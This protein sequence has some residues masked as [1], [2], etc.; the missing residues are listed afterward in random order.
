MI[1]ILS[2]NSDHSTF[3]VIDWLDLWGKKWIKFDSNNSVRFLNLSIN[4]DSAS[5]DFEVEGHRISTVDIE[6]YWYRRDDFRF[7]LSVEVSKIGLPELENQLINHVNS[8][9]D[10]LRS[11]LHEVLAQKK[12]INDLRTSDLNK[13]DMLIKAQK[14][15]L[16]IP[17]TII[18]SNREDFEKFKS[19]YPQL[20]SKAIQ[21][22][23]RFQFEQEEELL[24]FL[25]YTEDYESEPPESFFPTLFQEKLDKEI[26]LRV[27]FL[28]GVCYS[29]AIFS[30]L[31]QRTQTDFR[32]YNLNR[33]NRN[34]PFKLPEEIESKVKVLMSS[35]NL[36]SGSIDFVLT[37][38][39][40]Y[41]FLE[42]N[43]VGQFG[44]VSV[45]CNYYLERVIAKYL[46]EA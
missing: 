30:Q 27:F 28:A 14:A 33:P 35:L 18:T 6:S 37:R 44:M 21:H 11:G 38:N 43:P 1:F 22:G 32:N 25:C 42:V 9:V 5:F 39:G 15:G 36:N 31:D 3:D 17:A 4:Q 12:H 45:P 8:E 20:I 13:L 7:D 23:A 34:V 19:K 29:M 24:S 46:S 16:K 10:F 40:D 26:E 41:V 2:S